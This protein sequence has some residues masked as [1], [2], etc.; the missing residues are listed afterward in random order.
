MAA[1]TSPLASKGST[2]AVSMMKLLCSWVTSVNMKKMKQSKC[3]LK[4]VYIRIF[5]NTQ[6]KHC[7]YTNIYVLKQN[8][9]ILTR[10]YDRV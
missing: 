7:L 9:R 4:D 3:Y 8:I 5:I 6:T 2:H 1:S 10:L